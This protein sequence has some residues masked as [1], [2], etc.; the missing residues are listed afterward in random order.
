MKTLILGL[1]LFNCLFGVEIG[2]HQ[3]P[4]RRV[5]VLKQI[6]PPPVEGLWITVQQHHYED[7]TFHFRV[8]IQQTTG[9]IITLR[10]SA[11]FTPGL[12]MTIW[13]PVGQVEKI[14]S[15]NIKEEQEYTIE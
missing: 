1:A 5:I 15:I 4:T 7:V 9:K 2:L 12:P 3:T 6:A 11:Q 10:K 13:L 14:I 8:V